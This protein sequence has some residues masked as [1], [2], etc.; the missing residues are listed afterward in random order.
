MVE[1]LEA[2]GIKKKNLL[3]D[4]RDRYTQK[5][6]LF[7]IQNKITAVRRYRRMNHLTVFPV[8]KSEEWGDSRRNFA[9]SVFRGP[10]TL[11][12]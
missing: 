7:M 2:V 11:V 3:R 10:H 6:V 4:T 9:Y 8:G 5:E 1:H 12:F